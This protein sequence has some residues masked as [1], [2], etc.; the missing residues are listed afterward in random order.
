LI[1]EL[2]N[3]LDLQYGTIE[4]KVKNGEWVHTKIGM[5]FNRNECEILENIEILDKSLDNNI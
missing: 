4:I 5:D 1:Q 3:S 2:V